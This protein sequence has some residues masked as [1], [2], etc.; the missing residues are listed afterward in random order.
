MMNW[1]M[2]SFFII[3]SMLCFDPIILTQQG[4]CQEQP[5]AAT[6]SGKNYL[7]YLHGKIIEDQGTR[8]KHPHYGFYEYEKILA[9]FRE[10]GFTVISEV[11]SPKTDVFQYAGK[12]GK[13]IEELLQQGIP[14]KN[15]LVVGASKGGII[16]IIVSS[17]L[18]TK[19]I[20]YVYMGACSDKI[21]EFL[22]QKKVFVNGRILSIFDHSDGTANS[23]LALIQTQKGPEFNRFDEKSINLGKGHGFLYQP[24][25]EWVEPVVVWARNK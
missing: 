15:I 20:G 5:E 10:K 19:D 25:K 17:L 16:T 11:R 3:C 24:F 14:G 22:Q 7:I 23:C 9:E 1:K 18:Q 8:P 13:Q 21:I 2:Y 4:Y 6:E 12:V